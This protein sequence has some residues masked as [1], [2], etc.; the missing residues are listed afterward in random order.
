MNWFKLKLNGFVINL[1]IMTKA[2][3]GLEIFLKE[4]L[5]ESHRFCLSLPAIQEGI[6]EFRE[7][8]S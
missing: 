7:R 5:M 1:I 8:P 6:A 2:V 3:S 4:I